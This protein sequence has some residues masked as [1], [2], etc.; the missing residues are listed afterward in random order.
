M[1]VKRLGH[2]ALLCLLL[3]P[4]CI[5]ASG[6]AMRQQ[7]DG[8]Y[9]LRC[10]VS[11]ARCLTAIEE[12]CGSGYDI[13]EGR[14]E[15]RLYGPLTPNEPHVRSE[16]VA[17][18]RSTGAL[19]GGGEKPGQPA[20]SAAAVPPATLRNCTPGATQACVGPAACKGGQRCLADGMAF[21]PCDCGG[22]AAAAPAV[23]P[24]APDTGATTPR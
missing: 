5:H 12:V 17:R 23:P 20:A 7:D 16:V 6:I 19:F 3:A 14:E 22:A 9:R 21:G 8:S 13:S 11:L 4:A 18:C 24:A 15:S 1:R 10:K 2:A